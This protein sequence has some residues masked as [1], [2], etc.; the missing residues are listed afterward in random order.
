MEEV[1]QIYFAENTVI[2]K[3]KVVNAKFLGGDRL[4]CFISISMFASFKNPWAIIPS[5]SELHFR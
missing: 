2:N 4:F 3:L 5:L 1:N